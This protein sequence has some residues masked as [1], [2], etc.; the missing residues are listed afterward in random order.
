M[1]ARE[2]AA[3]VCHWMGHSQ[4]GPAV[5]GD[6]ERAGRE[7]RSML[8]LWITEPGRLLAGDQGFCWQRRH[9]PREPNGPVPP[10][11]LLRKGVRLVGRLDGAPGRPETW[12]CRTGRGLSVCGR[13][14]G[15]SRSKANG[16]RCPCPRARRASWW[17]RVDWAYGPT[18]AWFSPPPN[19]V[20][21]AGPAIGCRAYR[22]GGGA[23]RP[24]RRPPAGLPKRSGCRARRKAATPE[25]PV[26]SGGSYAGRKDPLR[27]SPQRGPATTLVPP[28]RPQR[29]CRFGIGR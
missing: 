12:P 11:R 28:Q 25:E 8:P 7:R 4:I 17:R 10:G 24:R 13:V 5:V 29:C 14:F 9:A 18:G 23:C 16:A 6:G 27:R 2:S 21:F 1:L 26:G 15:P 3:I 19:E 20:K 22:A